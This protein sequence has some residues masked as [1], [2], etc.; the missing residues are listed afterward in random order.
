MDWGSVPAWLGAGSLLL[1]FK[2]FLRDRT[3]RE[4]SQ[5]ERIG[6]WAT[7]AYTRKKPWD[8]DRIEVGRV[9][10]FVKNATDLPVT[11]AQIAFEMHTSWMVIDRSN[12]NPGPGEQFNTDAPG[13][14]T[15]KPGTS[16]Q[17]SFKDRLVIPPEDTVSWEDEVNFGHM[18]PE[19]AM[20]PAM[21]HGLELRVKWMLVVDNA[22]RRWEVRPTQRRSIRRVRWLHRRKEY[23]PA[24]W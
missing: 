1:A 8:R 4:Q 3:E 23:Q 5:V 20:Q 21:W 16:T 2:I 14:W 11:V 10:V 17:L 24:D 22:G 18:A 12:W 19:D 7:A 9:K 15:I 13:V 6:V